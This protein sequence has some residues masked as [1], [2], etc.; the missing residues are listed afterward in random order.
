[1]AERGTGMRFYH[2]NRFKKLVLFKKTMF[3]HKVKNLQ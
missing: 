1:M 3:D 2:K